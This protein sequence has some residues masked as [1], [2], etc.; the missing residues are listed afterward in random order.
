MMMKYYT[1]L[2]SFFT[3]FNY[4][5][6]QTPTTIP[7]YYIT[8]TNDTVIAQIK[9]PHYIFSDSVRLTKFI[10]KVEIIDS[11]NRN[12]VF[13]VNDIK[14]FG[15][16]FNENRY[17]F[18]SKDFGRENAFSASTHRFYQAI[19]LGQKTSLYHRL[20]TVD[21]SGRKLGIMYFLENA[22]GT[23]QAIYLFARTKPEFIKSLL[24]KFYKDNVEAQTLIDSK[25]QSKFF[26]AWQND[27]MEIV[28]HI[29]KL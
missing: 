11:L 3:L 7:G 25:F 8:N 5:Y 1:F 10:E 9:L 28:Q 21:Q 26:E 14:G 27:I 29:N 2:I 12:M 18:L 22:D 13:R 16:L 6:S 17:T 20:T 19:F 15:F 4:A 24:K 23:N